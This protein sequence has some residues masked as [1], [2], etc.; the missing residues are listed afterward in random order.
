MNQ[1]LIKLIEQIEREYVPYKTV[2]VKN[3]FKIMYVWERIPKLLELIKNGAE[4]R[5]GVPAESA[6]VSK[7][8]EPA[9]ISRVDSAK[10]HCWNT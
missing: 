7:E 4:T 10:G 5:D 2:D 9:D 3:W 1:E 6:S 8:N